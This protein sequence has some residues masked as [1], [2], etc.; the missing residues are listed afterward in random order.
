MDRPWALDKA[1]AVHVKLNHELTPSLSESEEMILKLKL[2]IKLVSKVGTE[3]KAID[4]YSTVLLI[5]ND[6]FETLIK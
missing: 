2:Q 1:S 6:I 5:M 3:A 4:I